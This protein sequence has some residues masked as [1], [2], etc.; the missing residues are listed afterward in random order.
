LAKNDREVKILKFA[1]QILRKSMLDTGLAKEFP[2]IGSS[3]AAL[4]MTPLPRKRK[5]GAAKD[6]FA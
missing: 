3:F 2:S 6:L 5:G 4:R 1:G